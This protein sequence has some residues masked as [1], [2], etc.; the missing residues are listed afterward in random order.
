MSEPDDSHDLPALRQRLTDA[1]AGLARLP[2]SKH[3]D[4]GP[5]DP[6]TGESW[7]RGNVL[8]HMSEML[9]YWTDQIRRAND[10]SGRVGRDQE[11][12]TKRRQGIEQGD[13]AAEAELKLAVDEEIGSVLELLEVLSSED[14]ERKVVFHNRE[15]DR[16]ARLGE[17]VQRLVVSHLEE[18]VAQLAGLG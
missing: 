15:G 3:G 7:H 5:V 11:G 6:T 8:G 9:A 12:A 4:A 17:L 1:R 10:G 18:H 16:D 2:V 14:L 13:A